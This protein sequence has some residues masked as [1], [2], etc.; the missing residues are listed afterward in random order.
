[1]AKFE[2]GLGTAPWGEECVQVPDKRDE[3]ACALYPELGRN[4]CVR[5]IDTLR[6]AYKQVHGEE[7]PVSVRLKIKT[8]DHDFGYYFDVVASFDEDDDAARTAAYW[9]ENN[10]PEKWID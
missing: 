6:K 5:W 10:S 3:A 1:M 8:F 4:E 2:L 7:I 9:L